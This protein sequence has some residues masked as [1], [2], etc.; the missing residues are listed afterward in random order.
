MFRAD[1]AGSTKEL[2]LVLP[3]RRRVLVADDSPLVR[4]IVAKRVAAAGLEAWPCESVVTARAAPAEDIACALL[5]LDLGDGKGTDVAVFLRAARP[6]LPIA[7]FSGSAPE[8]A[9]GALSFGPVFVKPDELD[10]AIA[11][12]AAHAESPKVD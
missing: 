12:I 7:F 4:D 10:E 11:W 2:S 9:A 5:D 1:G 8:L 6:D 3:S